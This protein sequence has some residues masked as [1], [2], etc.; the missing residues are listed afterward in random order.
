MIKKGVRKLPLNWLKISIF[1]RFLFRGRRS[2]ISNLGI[3]YHI[4]ISIHGIVHRWIAWTRNILILNISLVLHYKS[5][6]ILK[7]LPIPF[8]FIFQIGN[9]LLE[10]ASLPLSNHIAALRL[11]I[12]RG[13]KSIFCVGYLHEV[14]VSFVSNFQ[15]ISKFLPLFVHILIGNCPSVY[16][17]L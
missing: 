6:L 13:K 15:S 17:T 12:S 2:R 14:V 8:P 16:S 11:L 4:I 7:S 9:I 5:P 10:V 1:R 3:A